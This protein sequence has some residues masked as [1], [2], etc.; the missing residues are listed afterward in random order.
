MKNVFITSVLALML[1]T[2]ANAKNIYVSPDGSASNNG[3]SWDSPI[4]DLGTAYSKASKGDV[5]FMAGGTYVATA[6]INMVEG[7]DVYG[8]FAKGE[9]SIENRVRSNAAAE[10]WKFTNETVITSSGDFRLVDRVVKSEYWEN[11]AIIDGITFKG[12]KTKDKRVLYLQ[13]SVTLQNC[14]IIDNACTSTVVYGEENTH[15]LNCYFSGNGSTDPTKKDVYTLQ[16]RGCHK[17]YYPGSV[18]EGCLFEGNKVTCL[19]VYNENTDGNPAG[20][21]ESD[22]GGTLVTKNIFRNNQ[23]NCVQINN[24]WESRYLKVTYCLFEGNE[25]A[26]EGTVLSGNSLSKENCEFAYNVVRNNTNTAPVANWRYGIISARGG[27]DIVNCLIVN[28]ASDKLLMDLQTCQVFS[29]TIANNEGTVYADAYSTIA[30]SVLINNSPTHKDVPVY[31][32]LGAYFEYSGTDKEVKGDGSQTVTAWLME[33][34]PFVN[35]TTFVG[36]ATSDNQIKELENADF[37]LNP[38]STFVNTGDPTYCTVQYGKTSEWM[39]EFMGK[40]I[41]G[42]TRIVD[43]K[44]NMGAYQGGKGTGVNTIEKEMNC[45]VTVDAGVVYISSE[46]D[47]YAT[48][49]NINGTMA[50]SE[51]IA[52]GNATI[53]VVREGLYLV[54]VVTNNQTKTFKVVIK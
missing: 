47:G 32:P 52:G 25:S 1:A 38:S 5:I 19:S 37:S 22:E 2:G 18:A 24:K 44:I 51:K 9:T 39:A 40:D 35:P 26:V 53:P 29:T 43:G 31:L 11:G 34:A 13:N 28:N 23:T 15:I 20:E 7:V 36:L 48:L 8:G 30:N 49:Y 41:A 4:S 27:M 10:P 45:I 16:L 50:A 54:K 6:T 33:A 14:M 42:N 3:E 21:Q 17:A 46:Q 12:H